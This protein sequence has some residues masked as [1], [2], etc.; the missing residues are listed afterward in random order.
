MGS[1]FALICLIGGVA[2]VAENNA[3]Q[4]PHSSDNDEIKPFIFM[5]IVYVISTLS[6]IILNLIVILVYFFGQ[7]TKTEISIFLV[8][9]AIGD[10]LMSTFC[11]PFT[12]AQVLL[13]RWIFGEIMC[14]IGTSESPIYLK[15]IPLP[16]LNFL[17]QFYSNKCLRF[18]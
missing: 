5:C 4:P 18:P 3:T 14:P 15:T 1:W 8:N 2:A 9:L 13:K 7:K 16:I 6:A 10:F 17:L 12:F 11:M